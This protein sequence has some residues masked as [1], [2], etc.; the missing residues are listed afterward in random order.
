MVQDGKIQQLEDEVK[1]LKNEIKHVLTGI[2]ECI[3][4]ARNPFNA[5]VAVDVP[6]LGIV[7][8]QPAQQQGSPPPQDNGHDP[9][10]PG[11]TDEESGPSV[12][13]PQ[14]ADVESNGAEVGQHT[15]TSS[16]EIKQQA[17]AQ[18]AVGDAGKGAAARLVSRAPGE[19]HIESETLT[20]AAAGKDGLRQ[21]YSDTVALGT[22]VALSQW[23]RVATEKIGAKRLKTVV[24]ICR[25]ADYITAE[26]QEVILGLTQLTGPQK[27][28][29]QAQVPMRTSMALLAQL[30]T[31][32]EQRGESEDHVLSLILDL[33]EE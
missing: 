25:S 7:I 10:Q 16:G 28:V 32:L 26:S 27:R 14:T 20:M 3:L 8:N 33:A 24:E 15:T 9:A 1:L 21:G 23:V 18:S 31:I 4:N 5:A 17:T 29:T 30:R 11:S 2:E 6:H 13:G 12:A 19:S 22:M